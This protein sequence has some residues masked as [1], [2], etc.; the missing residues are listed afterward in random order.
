MEE[1]FD[2]WLEDLICAGKDRLAVDEIKKLTVHMLMMACHICTQR[3]KDFEEALKLAKVAAE[4]DPEN[5]KLNTS[6]A[7]VYLKLNKPDLALEFS[8]KA[9]GSELVECWVNHGL[10]L[11]ARMDMNGAKEAFEKALTLAP[12]NRS[13]HEK[14]AYYY[15]INKEYEKSLY[16][17]QWRIYLSN[18][19]P[20][21]S[22]FKNMWDGKSSLKE[23]IVLVF[24]AH[25]FGDII[26]NSRFIEYLHNAGA[27]TILEVDKAQIDIFDSVKGLNAIVARNDTLDPT[28]PK[29]NYDYAVAANAIPYYFGFSFSEIKTDPYLNIP[30]NENNVAV[31]ALKKYDN[32]KKI[33]IIWAGNRWHGGDKYRSCPLR[34]FQPFS[35]IDTIQ[36]IGLQK[37]DMK[38]PYSVDG[39]DLREGS[40][41]E[42]LD[43]M[44]G[45]EN[46]N[47]IDVSKYLTDFRQTAEILLSLDMLISVDSS[48]SH[49]AGA[50][51]LPTWLLL[52]DRLYDWRWNFK[53][54]KNHVIFKQKELEDWESLI[55]EV[56]NKLKETI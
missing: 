34:Y 6:I 49:L 46:V 39:E 41:V 5:P 13:L 37:G 50:I 3:T 44:E 53:L 10:I 28:P 11:E 20:F 29:V 16:Q 40:E 18:G 24:N 54:Y 7:F 55:R 32:K 52:S 30:K 21:I 9:I 2:K 45:S 1:Y 35:D 17:D 48:V 56:A 4:L 38:R 42:V 36:L 8:N 14:L 43:L 23:K 15:A 47:F 33:G 31:A 12:E 19:K 22:R 25:G 27:Y 51:G 26:Q